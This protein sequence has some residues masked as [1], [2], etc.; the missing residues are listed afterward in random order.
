MA[1]KGHLYT[2]ETKA[3]LVAAQDQALKTKN[4]EEHITKTVPNDE[5]RVSQSQPENTDNVVSAYPILAKEVY[6]QRH[7]RVFQSL[8]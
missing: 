3:L 8:R 6:I 4:F 1:E 2:P 7:D 5:C